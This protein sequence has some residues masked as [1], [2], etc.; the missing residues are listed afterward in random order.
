ML[1]LFTQFFIYFFKKKGLNLL[2]AQFL[3]QPGEPRKTSFS[4][5]P[6]PTARDVSLT[7]HSNINRPTLWSPTL[8]MAVMQMGQFIDHDV[9]LTP[10]EEGNKRIYA[11]TLF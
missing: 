8:T 11:C 5:N 7:V 10:V 3:D 2:I 6:L 4:G 1:K 9:I